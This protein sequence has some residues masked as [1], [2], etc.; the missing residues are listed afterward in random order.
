MR[1]KILAIAFILTLIS[2]AHAFQFG[3]SKRV[4][5]FFTGTQAILGPYKSYG[6][7][8]FN[9]H[10]NANIEVLRPG[11]ERMVYRR[12]LSH[13]Y[14]PRYVLFQGTIYPPATISSFLET[15]NPEFFNRFKLY[16][17]MNLLKAVSTGPEEPYALSAFLGNILFFSRKQPDTS[18]SQEIGQQVGSALIGIVASGG[19][20][21]IQ[22]NIRIDDNWYEMLVTLTG[23]VVEHRRR[24][25]NW[26]F[27]FGLKFHENPLPNDV[28][29]LSIYHSHSDFN[30]TRWSFIRNSELF[31]RINF[32]VSDDAARLPLI[33][34]FYCV[35]SKKFPFT[36]F[37]HK[38]LV[39]IGG[40]FVWAKLRRF[41]RD[42]REFDKDESARLV[43]LFKPNIEF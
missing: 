30:L 18:Q 29:V 42:I 32:P 2:S 27:Q 15:D 36:I 39:K 3:Y 9:F 25:M 5:G 24:K 35:Y 31:T 37:N 38:I 13:A 21:H 22:D 40:G 10:R 20:W 28:A 41:D 11:E 4:C 23:R 17:G 12:L 43:W 1:F 6:S 34:R 16:D 14:L 8:Y 19:H 7:F 26:N 33:S